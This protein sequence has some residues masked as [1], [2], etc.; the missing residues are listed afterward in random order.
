VGSITVSSDRAVSTQ[1]FRRQAAVNRPPR[2]PR[3]ARSL[4]DTASQNTLL[5]SCHTFEF[6]WYPDVDIVVVS[7]RPGCG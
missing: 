6:R 5:N 3:P 2:P 7:D 4:D 1:Q